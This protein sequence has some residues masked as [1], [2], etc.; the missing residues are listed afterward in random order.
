MRR[1]IPLGFALLATACGG[2]SRRSGS[3][4]EDLLILDAK[5]WGQPESDALWIEGGRI[6][7]AGAGA[8]LRGLAPADIRTFS[9]RGGLL[10]P[11]LHDAHAHV[12]DGGESLEQL[13]LSGAATLTEALAA[14]ERRSKG[15]PPGEILR[16]RGWSYDIVPK[17][18]FPTR[19]GLDKAAPGRPVVLESYDGHAWWLSSAALA[20]AGIDA[21]TPDSPG[22]AIA[23]EPGTR[24]PEG[25]LIECG[26]AELGRAGA[27]LSGRAAW[28]AMSNGLKHLAGL[29]FTSVD[30]LVS[31]ASEIELLSALE[32]A[33]KLPLRVRVVAPLGGDLAAY[34]GWRGKL[35]GPSLRFGHLKAFVDG[36]IESRTAWMLEPY[37]GSEERGFPQEDPEKLKARVVEAHCRGF[38]AAL[39]AIGDAAVRFALDS[40]AAA[41]AA[42]PDQSPR[43]RIEHIE[44]LHPDDLPRFARLGVVASMQPFHAHPATGDPDAGVWSQNLGPERLRGSFPWRS[45]LDHGAVLAFG[46][47]WPIMSAD[48]MKGLAVAGTRRN[49][50]G[51]PEGG[52]NAHQAISIEEAVRAYAFGPA[53]AAGREAELGCLKAGCL[54]DLVVLEP[55]ARLEEPASFWTARL[56]LVV[57]GGRPDRPL[58]RQSVEKTP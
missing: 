15:L 30:A 1:L 21:E 24:V 10:L 44:T 14:V 41:Q 38:A 57:A 53:F 25:A 6:R 29:G 43:H 47:D 27:G 8:E 13:D 19:A 9:A 56:R 51:K 52:W 18:K 4:P 3:V 20:L 12:L 32:R 17:G 28:R 58:D 36:V 46:S 54:A 50:E 31:D 40:F 39:H 23:R 7:A 5:I 45:L 55:G 48:P 35:A 34:E 2:L 22:C 16:G 26:R 37:A 11:G 33:R 49:V 42:C